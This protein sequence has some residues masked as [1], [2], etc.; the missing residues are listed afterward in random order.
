MRWRLVLGTVF[1]V[2][3]KNDSRGPNCDVPV[4]A[5]TEST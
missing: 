4:V 2:L 1:R 3:R 5:A